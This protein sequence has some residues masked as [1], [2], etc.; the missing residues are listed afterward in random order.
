[1]C[2]VTPGAEKSE[3]E[4]SN[5]LAGPVIRPGLD[6]EHQQN[7]NQDDG[8]SHASHDGSGQP[9]RRSRLRQLSWLATR[10]CDDGR[11]RMRRQR[12]QAFHH[13]HQLTE[14]VCGEEKV[15]PSLIVLLLQ[16]SGGVGSIETRIEPIAFGVGNRG[17]WGAPVGRR[18][19]QIT[20]HLSQATRGR[21]LSS[22]GSKG[23]RCPSA[24]LP[25]SCV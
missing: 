12:W 3:L 9:S 17:V 20:A 13:G 6:Q 25:M 2:L 5:T 10:V 23:D 8:G 14:P 19:R 22:D 18:N 21:L 7:R 15:Q 4:I 16:R 11:R 24:T 1:M